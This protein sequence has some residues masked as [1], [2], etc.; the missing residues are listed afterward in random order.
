MPV[1]AARDELQARRHLGPAHTRRRPAVARELAAALD[2]RARAL[3]ERLAASPEPWLARELGVLAP[4]GSPALR[5]AQQ[6][7]RHASSEYAA[8]MELEAQ[9][10]AK[11]GQWAEA[12][13]ETPRASTA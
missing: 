10:Q 11:A 4:G 8:R 5:A 12:R 2:G 7:E 9:T 1:P 6:A 13:N 3:G